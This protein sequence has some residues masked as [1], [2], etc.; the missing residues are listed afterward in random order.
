MHQQGVTSVD[1]YVDIFVLT[2]LP[3]AGE[4]QKNVTTKLPDKGESP[5]TVI[6][7]LE[8]KLDTVVKE[9]RLPQEILAQ[10]CRKRELLFLIGTCSQAD[11]LQYYLCLVQRSAD[12]GV[13]RIFATELGT[14]FN[15]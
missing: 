12:T 9:V 11:Y 3:G 15:I 5:A 13:C 2:G 10:S 8:I 14:T 1:H 4:C 7:V 6:I